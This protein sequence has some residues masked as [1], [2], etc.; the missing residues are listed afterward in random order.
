[1]NR[2]F[3]SLEALENLFMAEIQKSLPPELCLLHDYSFEHWL[4]SWICF[5]GNRH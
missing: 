4:S 1:M 2:C 3:A 5:E